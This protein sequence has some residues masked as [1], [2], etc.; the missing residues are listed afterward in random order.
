M[1]LPSQAKKS[2]GSD[3]R[4]MTSVPSPLSPKG[5]PD[6]NCAKV[7]AGIDP[8]DWKPF[9]EV[10]AGVREIRIKDAHGIYR[11]MYVARFDEAVY[12][13][14]CFQKKTETT[15]KRDK[16]I[17]KTRYRSILHAR[18]EVK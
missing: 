17:A 5:K 7:Q 8:D 15:T 4:L 18:K 3:H 9:G 2:A 11:V 14:H 1:T 12:V 13:L 10:G 6:F 16:E